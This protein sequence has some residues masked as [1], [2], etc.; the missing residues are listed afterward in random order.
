[1]EREANAEMGRTPPCGDGS[2]GLTHSLWRK[3]GSSEGQ[4]SEWDWGLWAEL[5]EW[6]EHQDST[7]TIR[8]SDY[9]GGGAGMGVVGEG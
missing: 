9:L 1:M 3:G 5:G 2:P 4:G 6:S 8:G 7:E